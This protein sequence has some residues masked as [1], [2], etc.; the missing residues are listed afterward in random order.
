MG[1]T[2]SRLWPW[3]ILIGLGLAAFWYARGTLF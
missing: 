1:S 3:L 2:R